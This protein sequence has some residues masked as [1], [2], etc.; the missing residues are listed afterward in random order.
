MKND[1]SLEPGR[2][3]DAC[4]VT[5]GDNLP[6]PV[7]GGNSRIV[8]ALAEFRRR[9]PCRAKAGARAPAQFVSTRIVNDK[10]PANADPAREAVAEL[11]EGLDHAKRLVERTRSLLTGETAYDADEI[12]M[13]AA[14][15]AKTP[16]PPD[17]EPERMAEPPPE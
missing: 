4:L 15:A 13:I 14:K 6:P 8:G 11:Q 5:A 12:T 2:S 7:A 10:V 9:R 1:E 17:N 3:P 16:P